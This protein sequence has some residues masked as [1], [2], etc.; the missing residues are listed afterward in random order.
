M[1]NWKFIASER[2]P[3]KDGNTLKF[4][5]AGKYVDRDIE[6]EIPEVASHAITGTGISTSGA[7]ASITPS[8]STT[9]NGDGK[10]PISGSGTISGSTSGTA[11]LTIPTQTIDGKTINGGWIDNGTY[12]GTVTGSVSGTASASGAID[13]IGLSADGSIT[14]T[15]I[16]SVTVGTKSS[17]KYPITGS[18]SISGSASAGVATTGFGVKGVE[19]ASKTLSGTA[20]VNTSIGA[21]SMSVTGSATV[22]PNGVT[23]ANGNAKVASTSTSTTAP[24]SGYYIGVTPSTAASTPIT[25]TKG[26]LTAGYL[27]AQSEISTSGSVTG[28]SGSKHYV[29]IQAGSI[30]TAASDPGTGY[31]ENTTAAVSSGGY[32]KL[33]EGY[34]PATKISLGTL[35]GDDIA[36]ITST[37]ASSS[38]LSGFRAY[39]KDGN[40]LLGNIETKTSSNLSASGATVTVPAGYYASQATKSVASGSVNSYAIDETTQASKVVTAGTKADGYY[41]ISVPSLTG[42]VNRTAGYISGTTSTAADSNGG[43]VGKIAASTVSGSNNS[44]TASATANTTHNLASGTYTTSATTGYT[45][46][47]DATASASVADVS[48]SKTVSAGYND[49]ATTATATVTGASSGNKSSNIYIKDSTSSVALTNNTA[50]VALGTTLTIGKGYYSADRVY[51]IPSASGAAGSTNITGTLSSSIDT[52]YTAPTLVD[53]KASGKPYVTLTGNG[54]ATSGKVYSGTATAKTQYLEVYTGTYSVS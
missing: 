46:H 7:T 26:T 51:T 36:S 16:T 24:E 35:I 32:L 49:S 1:A 8:V 25:Q 34:Y 37:T 15:E 5:T 38:M 29:Q 54:S 11:T 13:P 18:K 9:K 27:G 31:T 19:T 44:A 41:P 3:N 40:V 17:G 50:T 20:S 53:S 52:G 45:Y 43:V 12:T 2:Y 47:V 4:T 30:G 14:N 22:K 23:A 28:G 42:T 21:A 48:A 6:V 39:D 10:Y 33:D